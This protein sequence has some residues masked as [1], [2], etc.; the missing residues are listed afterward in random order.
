MAHLIVPIYVG[1]AYRCCDPATRRTEAVLEGGASVTGASEWEIYHATQGGGA[2]E[3]SVVFGVCRAVAVDIILTGRIETLDTGY[4]S[5][6]VF[7]NGSQVF[8]HASTDSSNDADETE[9]AGPFTVTLALDDRPCGH[10]I[11][12]RGG[13]G[14]DR[15]NNGVWWKASVSVR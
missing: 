8:L 4:D 6:E 5:I 2:A 3:G 14:D 7:H 12:I 15:A 13:T 1:G 10:V 11:E 9:A